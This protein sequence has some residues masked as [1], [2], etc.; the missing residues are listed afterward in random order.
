MN[1]MNTMNTMDVTNIISSLPKELITHIYS[2]DPNHR[3]RLDKV[4]EELLYEVNTYICNND[5]CEK[6]F[7]IRHEDSV[8]DVNISFLTCNF[9]SKYCESYG[10]WSITYDLRKRR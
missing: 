2:Y 1:T 9:C 4:H 10:T 8:T 3:I 7:D 5:M 6:E